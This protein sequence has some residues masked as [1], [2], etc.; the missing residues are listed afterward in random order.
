M[1]RVEGPIRIADDHRGHP[2]ECF[3]EGRRCEVCGMKLNR[4]NSGVL[5]CQ[6]KAKATPRMGTPFTAGQ[7]K[8]F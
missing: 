2:P 5:C 3:G 1:S 6:C 8:H 7:M 4:Y